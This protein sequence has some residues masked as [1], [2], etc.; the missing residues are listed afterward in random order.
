AGVVGPLDRAL[1]RFRPPLLPPPEVVPLAP[2]LEKLPTESRS[3]PLDEVVAPEPGANWLL[4]ESSEDA[5]DPPLNMSFSTRASWRAS[6][7]LT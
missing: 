3:P 2:V 5:L 1:G 4:W 6:P 7:N